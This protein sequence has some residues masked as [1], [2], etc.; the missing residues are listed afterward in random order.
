MAVAADCD[1]TAGLHFPTVTGPNYTGTAHTDSFDCAV[2]GTKQLSM[3]EMRARQDLI[4]PNLNN[5][6]YIRLGGNAAAEGLTSLR[7]GTPDKSTS[8][9]VGT[10]SV[11]NSKTAS[12]NFE[13]AFGYTW[14]EFAIDLEWLALKSVQVTANINGVTPTFSFTSTVKGDVLVGN[15]YWIFND[16]YNVKMYGVLCGGY[17]HNKSTNTITGGQPYT[18]NRY[19]LAY[20]GGVGARFNV[21]SKAY[22]DISARYILL[23]AVRL[24]ATNGAEYFYVKGSR[25]WIGAS[26]RILWLI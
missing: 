6:F 3:E 19:Y 17:S 9:A 1:S 2:S 21:I 12:N 15:L 4:P 16:M 8:P 11:T 7:T 20:G 22:A 14:N 10:V 23:G 24:S 5:R 13:L 18:M 26:V 25:T